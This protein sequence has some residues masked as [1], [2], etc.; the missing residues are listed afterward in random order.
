LGTNSPSGLAL[1][2]GMNPVS[3]ETNLANCCCAVGRLLVR[4]GYCEA[5]LRTPGCRSATD[6][7]GFGSSGI[8]NEGVRGVLEIVFGGEMAMLEEEGVTGVRGTGEW[9]EWRESDDRREGRA[10]VEDDVRRTCS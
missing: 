5:A 4:I 3:S 8:S 2:V 9:R 7:I 6:P 1:F 10:D